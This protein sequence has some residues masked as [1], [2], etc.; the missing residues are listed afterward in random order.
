MDY[1][2]LRQLRELQEA[3]H[4]QTRRLLPERQVLLLRAVRRAGNGR[5]RV[6]RVRRSSY[7]GQLVT[8]NTRA[9]PGDA[10]QEQYTHERNERIRSD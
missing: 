10:G 6:R 9:R 1:R 3:T 2:P 5:V 4:G 8:R 7:D